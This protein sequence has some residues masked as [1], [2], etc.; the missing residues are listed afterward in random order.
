MVPQWARVARLRWRGVSVGKETE[1]YPGLRTRGGKITIGDGV[2]TR[3]GVILQAGD[4]IVIGDHTDLNPYTTIYGNVS[5]GRHVMIAPL[6]MLAGGNHRSDDPTRP[7]KLQGHTSRGIVIE[8]DVWIG[9]N[10]VV[11]DGVR[12]GRGAIVAAGAVVTK[13][14]EPYAIVG[15]NPA[16]LL[17]YRPNRP[18][19]TGAQ[20]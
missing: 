10:A 9:A 18:V 1:I 16:K 19:E 15:G 11:V 6:V 3:E 17:K 2:R 13:D 5:I 12:I 14:V 8:D 4:A 20:A 7:M